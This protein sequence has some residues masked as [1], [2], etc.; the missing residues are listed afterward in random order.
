[1]SWTVDCAAVVDHQVLEVGR[2][3]SERVFDLLRRVAARADLDMAG[4][5]T[6]L[7]DDAIA[8]IVFDPRAQTIWVQG[9]FVRRR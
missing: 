3:R 9:I 1:M 8:V 6:L 7:A 2:E 4:K 5:A